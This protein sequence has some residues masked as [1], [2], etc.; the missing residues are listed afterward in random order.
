MSRFN[1]FGATYDKVVAMYPGSVLA[2][3]DG[4]GASGQT[5]IEEVLDRITREVAAAFTPEVYRQLTQV[6]AEEVV[7]YATAGQTTATLGLA[8]VVAGTVHLWQYPN[9]EAM[10]GDSGYAGF[11]VDYYRKPRKGYNE[12]SGYSVTAATG[13][14]T[15]ITALSLGD[16]LYATY[17]VD[18]DNAS[19]SMPSVADLV[20]LG[21]AAEV[22]AR[23][24]S[25]GTQEWKLV[26]E[27]R[28]RFAARMTEARE[29]RWIP[30]ELRKLNFW[31]E[32]E[33]GSDQVTSV[34]FY[35]A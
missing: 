23:L 26:E 5:R 7:R 21:T 34:R 14:V 35:R 8:P 31:E 24:Y 19:I 33:R 1:R 32:V 3:Y 2:D 9:P 28:A 15:A 11:S 4:G 25:E 30:D 10:S 27:Y 20:Y 17:D 18:T 12:L 16:R 6:D 13:A 22:G 29:G